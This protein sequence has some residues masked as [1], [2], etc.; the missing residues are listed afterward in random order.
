MCQTHKTLKIN[1]LIYGVVLVSS[2]EWMRF[3]K[4]GKL[5]AMVTGEGDCK[6]VL[7]FRGSS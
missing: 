4:N 6:T 3:P 1:S 7:T 5:S 2:D